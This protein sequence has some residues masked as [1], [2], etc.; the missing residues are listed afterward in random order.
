M[1]FFKKVGDSVK[2]ATDNLKQKAQQ[3]N[4]SSNRANNQKKTAG[5]NQ[6]GGRAINRD[7]I[8]N[9]RKQQQAGSNRAMPSIQ[10][11]N[12]FQRGPQTKGPGQ[13]LGGSKPGV[14][15]TFI[16][17]KEGPLGIKP[18][19]SETG[20]GCIIAFVQP[21]SQAAQ[22]GLVRGD[23]VCAASAGATADELA[24]DSDNDEMAFKEFLALV[25]SNQRPLV[26]TIR[27][28]PPSKK[29]AT[30]GAEHPVSRNANAEARRNAMI[31]AAEARDKAYKQ[32]M[33]L[34]KTKWR[35]TQKDNA[36]E[37]ANA[38]HLPPEQSED[39]KRLIAEAKAREAQTANQLGYNPYE[40][41]RMTSGQ[42]KTAM[43]TKE[44]GTVN[45]K[46]NNVNAPASN[47]PCSAQPPLSYEDHVMLNE[48]FEEG[49][50]TAVTS[51]SSS[52]EQTNVRAALGIMRKLILN[53]TTKGQT[54]GEGSEKFR[55]VR[56]QNAKIKASIID[57]AG[58]MDLMMACGFELLEGEGCEETFLVYPFLGSS[59]D[60]I[61]DWIPAA[62]DRMQRFEQGQI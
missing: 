37:D 22:A 49:Y 38:G 53:A 19:K 47:A 39:T 45:A 50:V 54:D 14:I 5:G 11:K 62:L 9:D 55:R 36:I 29:S 48:A 26:V 46:T 40:T 8:L 44:H 18:E 33:K 43:T 16:L 52:D 56:L 28:I 41:A 58:G 23:V 27:R 34:D 17:E 2:D 42:A 15:L 20:G 6:S 7:A 59:P 30:T 35:T 32:K 24:P 31:S 4:N 57:I 21:D 3:Q 61:P 1:D 60:G 13:T 12:P 10:L 51:S 25:Q